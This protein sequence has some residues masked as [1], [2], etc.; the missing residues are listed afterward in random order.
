MLVNW[1]ICGLEI[2]FPFLISYN[3]VK[4]HISTIFIP[5]ST[6]TYFL[7]ILSV[8]VNISKISRAQLHYV[9]MTSCEHLRIPFS[10]SMEREDPSVA[11]K[12]NLENV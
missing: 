10:V 12:G 9:M 4:L 11:N 5:I 1:Y 6:F 8:I 3:P 7:C 2:S